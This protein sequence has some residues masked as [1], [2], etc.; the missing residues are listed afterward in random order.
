[1]RPETLVPLL[2]GCAML[3]WIGRGMRM[4]TRLIVATVTLL[5]VTAVLFFERNI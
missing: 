1:M 3:W 2:A 4:T 5:I